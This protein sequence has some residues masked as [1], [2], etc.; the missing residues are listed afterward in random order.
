MQWAS[1]A[2]FHRAASTLAWSVIMSLSINAAISAKASYDDGD[3]C[4]TKP[5][6]HPHF[7]LG[8]LVSLLEKIGLNPQPLPPKAEGGALQHG[9]SQ[10]ADGE[11]P[12]CGNEP[13][14]LHFPPPP[15][16]LGDVFGAVSHQVMNA[17]M[18]A[19]SL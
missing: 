10:S 2:G 11:V 18:G 17:V 6:P 9:A 4:G 5:G 1:G 15:P 8:S 3:W 12:R 19:R 14:H 7:G 16:P 13:W